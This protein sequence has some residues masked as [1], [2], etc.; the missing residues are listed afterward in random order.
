VLLAGPVLSQD[1][2]PAGCPEPQTAESLDIGLDAYYNRGDKTAAFDALKSAADSGSPKAQWKLGRMYAEG[3]GI[4]RDDAKAFEL[5]S[6]VADSFADI[7][8]QDCNRRDAP[9][10][11]NAFVA[12]GSYL[13]DG[14]P[15]SGIKP[16]FDRA[17]QMFAY[18]ASYFGDSDAQV[19]LAMMFYEGEGGLRDSRQAA[20]WAKLAADKG[21]VEAQALLGHLLFQGDGVGRQPVLGLMF[22]SIALDRSS[23]HDDWI[24]GLHEQAF[25]LA[26]EAERRTAEA[27]KDAWLNKNPQLSASNEN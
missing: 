3:D 6:E 16:N 21:N 19:E 5:F 14:I 13:R 7:L 27:F 22:L 1:L 8:E 20:G 23:G 18:A 4:K 9:F 24:R 25:S 11:A 15:E 17:R 10:V 12:L 26:T 2:G